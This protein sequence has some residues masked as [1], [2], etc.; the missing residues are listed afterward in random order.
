MLGSNGL[1][2]LFKPLT[3]KLS[4]G[5][6]AQTTVRTF[7]VILPATGG[8]RDPRFQ[9]GVE[10]VP[11]EAFIAYRAVEI[12]PLPVLPGA[13]GRDVERRRL[14]PGQPTTHR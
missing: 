10:G 12:L 4:W 14:V 5:A 3:P 7:L 8:E 13:A 9:H 11:I 1:Q 6:I 2:L